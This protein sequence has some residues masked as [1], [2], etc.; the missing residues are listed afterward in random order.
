MIGLLAPGPHRLAK[1]NVERHE[2]AADMRKGAVENAAPRL[3]AVEAKREQA[4]D[5]PP[6]LRTAFDDREIVGR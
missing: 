5:H 4:A 1:A 6:A 3:V 2:A